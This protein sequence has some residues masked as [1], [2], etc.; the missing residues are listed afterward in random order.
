[1]QSTDIVMTTMNRID[2][3]KQSLEYIFERTR[4]PYA[5]HIIDDKSTDGTADYLIE[6][7]KLG[8]VETLVLHNQRHGIFANR[9]AGTWLAFSDPF[10]ITA[11]DV[12]CPDIEP[13]WL[14]TGLEV[15][16]RIPKLGILDLNHPT[17]YRLLKGEPD[18]EINYCLHVG[19][20]FGFIRRAVVENWN[21]PH[22]RGNFGY[23]NEIM[24]CDHAWAVG[25]KVGYLKH[26]Y[27]YHIG[28]KSASTGMDYDPISFVE[29]VDWKTLEPPKEF[30]P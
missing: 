2:Y 4:S 8:K 12:L 6:L 29:P 22:Y 17:A 16:A 24:L 15:M 26:T 23:I 3:L 5:L 30:I 28:K 27:C 1:M 20:T 25:Y 10:V 21:L 19:G 14:A 11:D 9:N 18:D 7:W 13:D